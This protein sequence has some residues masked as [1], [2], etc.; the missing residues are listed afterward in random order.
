MNTLSATI[1]AIASSEHLSSLCVTVGEDR[2]HLL[3]AEHPH[4]RIGEGVI[5]AFK[6][7]EILL[8][9]TL[10]PSTANVH[11]ATIT[12]IERGSVLT[13]VNLAYRDTLLTAL[14]PTATFDPL[15][16][17]EGDRVGWMVS[18]GE[19]SLLRGHHGD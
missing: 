12:R 16:M 3:L 15:G 17:A 2:F 7:T 1:T 6:E 9:Q 8:S 4:N 18:P 14:V 10:T 5:L 13:Q 11:A 19:I